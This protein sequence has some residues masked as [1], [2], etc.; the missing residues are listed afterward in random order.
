MTSVLRHYAQM[1]PRIKYFIVFADCSGYTLNANA[2]SNPLMS[3]SSFQSAYT[4]TTTIMT[5]GLAQD[6]GR[7]VTVYNPAVTGSPHVAVFRQVMM[8]NGP[9]IEG[10]SNTTAYVCTWSDNQFGV[11]PVQAIARTG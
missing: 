3:L 10:V 4:A 1:E 9:G 2:I 11:Y 5:P 8:V 6:L 7:S